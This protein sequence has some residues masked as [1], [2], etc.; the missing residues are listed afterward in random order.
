MSTKGLIKR[1]E[2]F[3]NV[4]EHVPDTYM[5]NLRM[6]EYQLVLTPHE[7][8]R[9]KIMHIKEAFAEKY[10]NNFA[11]YLPPHI[12][13]VKF[14]TWAMME[15]KIVQRLH[16]IAMGT[17]PFK[18]ELKDYESFP[19]HS[20]F[21]N[22]VS[23]LPI[24]SI[25]KQLKEAQRLMKADPEHDPHFIT[26]PNITIGRRLLPWQYEQGWNEY[27]YR[28]FTGRFI[29]NEMLLLKRRTGDKAWQIANHL[30]FENL[31]VLTKQVSLF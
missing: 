14:Q 20:I 21:I 3:T 25:V 2:R 27:N 30:Q 24:M 15:E 10:Q 7:E 12:C 18:V 8:L 13:L 4:V 16:H 9:K 26:D 19:S 31:P 17:A 22:V 23:K 28:Q 11:K 1:I 5:K 6:N 29:A